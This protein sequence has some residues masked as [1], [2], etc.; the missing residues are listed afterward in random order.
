MDSRCDHEVGHEMRSD[1]NF[2]VITDD[3]EVMATNDL[4]WISVF[5]ISLQQSDCEAICNG[6][7]ESQKC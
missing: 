3:G 2:V 4:E 5:N 7:T 6:Q 1:V